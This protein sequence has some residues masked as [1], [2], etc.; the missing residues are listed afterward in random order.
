M[1]FLSADTVDLVRQTQHEPAGT[2]CLSSASDDVFDHEQYE[3]DLESLR[4]VTKEL[5]QTRCG[6]NY[7]RLK[8]N[9]EYGRAVFTSEKRLEVELAIS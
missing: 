5:E 8:K 3:E 1:S 9:L 2:S 6:Q 4:R 7:R